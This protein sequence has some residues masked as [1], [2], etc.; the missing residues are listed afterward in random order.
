MTC[1]GT[2]SSPGGAKTNMISF[3]DGAGR[4]H[5]VIQ[6][7]ADK[8]TS[9][10]NDLFT[11]VAKVESCHVAASQERTIGGSESVSV[12]QAYFVSVGSQNASVGATQNIYVKGNLTVGVGSESVSIG[13]LLAEK[14]GDPASGA[15]NLAKAAAL[16]GASALGRAGALFA[17]AV[18][19][20]QG[21]IEGAKHGGAGGAAKG[22]AR[23]A[24]GLAAGFVPGGDSALAT[25]TS[26]S[27]PLPWEDTP[28]P[29]GNVA[30][31]GGA[32]AAMS[33]AS[34]AA[35][36]GPGHRNTQVSGGMMEVIG[37]VHA[38]A[39]PGSIGW[40]TTGAS[41]FVVAGSHT[42]KTA[43]ASVRVL[44]AS[45]ETLG[46]LRI[47]SGGILSRDVNG[48]LSA[49]IGGGLKSKAGGAHVISAKGN[50]TMK[51][52]GSLVLDGANVSFICGSSVV[53]AS[54][55]GVLI[56]AGTIK[57][58]GASKQSSKSTHT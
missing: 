46:S 56:K 47:K 10:A 12:K 33:D 11:Q 2:N 54:P 40:Q 39:S 15:A 22:A 21:A 27:A 49:T 5:F 1:F 41:T 30:A 26:A 44:G 8:T 48:A 36:P 53:S 18:P 57:I 42:T 37:A 45:Q 28:Q 43:A 55:G 50:L 25:I 24:L 32:G 51:V 9:V 52:G 23:G 38:I 4:E 58:T 20:V 34:G 29:P 17:Q 16:S 14:V 13:G 3:D 31:G 7:S 6:A 35:G 19:I